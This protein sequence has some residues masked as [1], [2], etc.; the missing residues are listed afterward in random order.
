VAKDELERQQ[1]ELQT[2]MERLEASKNLEA[3]ERARLEAEIQSKMQE[4]SPSDFFRFSF[5][6]VYLF[7]FP[8]RLKK[9]QAKC[10]ARRR[11][12]GCCSRRWRRPEGGR[13]RPVR[14]S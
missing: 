8:T 6:E 5:S 3:E 14:H 11:R 1:R 9:S 12:T 2:M 7:N 13:R 10:E 4:V